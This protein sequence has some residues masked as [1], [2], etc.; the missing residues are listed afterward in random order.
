M[1]YIVQIQSVESLNLP[2]VTMHAAD[3][4]GLLRM[5]ISPAVRHHADD[6]GMVHNVLPH[7]S[8]DKTEW[9][10]LHNENHHSSVIA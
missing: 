4:I 8:D 1:Y 2:H 5:V 3:V 6:G 7:K 9:R 10:A